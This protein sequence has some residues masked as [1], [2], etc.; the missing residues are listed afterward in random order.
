MPDGSVVLVEMFGPRIT[1]VH[2]DGTKETIAEIPGG[3]NGAAVGPDGALLP[4]QQRW[5]L[6]AG[7]ARPACCSRAGSTPT[8]TSAAGSSASIPA[9]A[10]VTDLYTECDGV[11]LRAPNDLVFDAHGGFWFTDH[12][13]RHGRTSD[14]T[15]IYY[16]RAD[17]SIDQRG[18]VPDRGPQRH[19]PVARRHARSYWAETHTGR[20]LR[21]T[22][23]APGEA[24]GRLRRSTSPPRASPGFPGCSCSTRWPSTATATCAWPRCS[25]VASPSSRPRGR[26]IDHVATGDA[27][28]TNICFGGPDLRTA[29]ITL[30]GTGRLV[31]TPW[32]RPRSGAG[33]RKGPAA[34]SR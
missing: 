16:A 9:R 21:R 31:S 30:S 22:V 20:V 10:T 34:L 33:L 19:R 23:T 4:L 12:G 8:A 25:T 27:M 3:P 24:R 7:R 2:P 13:I 15:G 14:L 26:S 17:G 5:L 11:P 29:Y 28:T 18:R 1:R 6:H 32:P